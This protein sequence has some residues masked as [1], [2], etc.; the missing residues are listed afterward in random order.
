M[1]SAEQLGDEALGELGRRGV[2]PATDLVAVNE[3]ALWIQGLLHLYCPQA[4][5]VL[6]FAHAAEYLA[7]AAS[8]TWPDP[9]A[10]ATW[11]TAQRQELVTGDPETVLAALEQLSAG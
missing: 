10:V 2:P 5:R 6:D 4:K 8:A 1:G 7:D 3:G 9:A 11:F